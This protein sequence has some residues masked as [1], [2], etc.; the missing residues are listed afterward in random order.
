MNADDDV[1]Y[2]T[3]G[4]CIEAWNCRTYTDK[5][6]SSVS[7]EIILGNENVYSVPP[8]QAKNK[9]IRIYLSAAQA[10]TYSINA[11]SPNFIL[12]ANPIDIT[13]TVNDIVNTLSDL[14]NEIDQEL[15]S[16]G[17][18]TAITN[19][20]DTGNDTGYL[21]VEITTVP[22]WDYYFSN[23][24]SV[25]PARFVTV[26]EAIDKSLEGDLH[27]IGKYD[28]EGELIEW[29]ASQKN[30]PSD[31]Q[32][33]DVFS[34]AG[35]I[36]IK[37]AVPHGIETGHE[38]LIN[39][40]TG[41]S[42]ANGRW[43][44]SVISSDTVE[45]LGSTFLNAYTGSG[46]MTIHPRG[47]G[48]VWRAVKDNVT[49]TWTNTRLIGSKALNLVTKKQIKAVC[50]KQAGRKRYVWTD[51][52]NSVSVLYDKTVNYQQDCLLEIIDPANTY[53]YD[54]LASE[55]IFQIG[56]A[57]ID[58]RFT[59][60]T[61]GGNLPD[62]NCRYA[63]RL[64]T[65]TLTPTAWLPLGI[66]NP[67]PA[68][69]AREDGIWDDFIGNE[70]GTT[71]GKTNNFEVSG[72]MVGLY[73]W[74]EL[75]VVNYSGLGKNA[76]I[77]GRYRITDNTMRLEHNGFEQNTTTIDIGTI[78]I[79]PEIYDRALSIDE[80]DGRVVLSNL[81]KDPVINLFGWFKTW[82]WDLGY[83]ELENSFKYVLEE[84]A[85]GGYQLSR[86]VYSKS[87]YLLNER[88]R[89]GAIVRFKNGQTAGVFH[90]ADAIFNT[91]N[92]QQGCV[93]AL[94][95]YNLTASGTGY[96]PRA[97]HIRFHGFDLDAVIDGKRVRDYVDKIYIVRAENTN[98]T[99]LA[100]G[101]IVPAVDGAIF[102]S[103]DKEITYMDGA[104][105]LK[106]GEW[107]FPGTLAGTGIINYLYGDS[108]SP[109]NFNFA[110][111][112]DVCSFYSWDVACGKADIQFAA[113][114]KIINFGQPQ[115]TPRAYGDINFNDYV[116]ETNGYTNTT[117]EII[118][119][120]EGYYVPAGGTAQFTTYADAFSKLLRFTYDIPNGNYIECINPYS[121]VVRSDGTPFL[122][123]NGH[124]E[125]GCYLAQYYRPKTAEQQYG[126]IENSRYVWTGS[127]YNI[128]PETPAIPTALDFP[129]VYGGDVFTQKTILKNRYPISPPKG[130]G[131]GIMFFAQ[132][133][134]N[135][136]MRYN[137]LVPPAGYP[138]I[139][140]QGFFPQQW[141]N[142]AAGEPI[143]NND[144]YSIR[145][146]TVL[147]TAFNPEKE[148]ND[149]KVRF[150]WSEKEQPESFTDM[151]RLFLPLNFKDLE[152][153]DGEVVHHESGNDELYAWQP[154]KFTR[155]YFN[156]N[157]LLTSND[158]VEVVLGSG[159]V[160][161][162][163]PLR[164]SQY[165]CSDP[166][167]IVK[168]IAEQGGDT[169]YWICRRKSA[170]LRFGYDGTTNQGVIKKMSS[171]FNNKMRYIKDT[172]PADGKGVHGIWNEKFKEAV[173][174]MR[175]W[176][177][178]P[179][180]E[181]LSYNQGAVVSYGSILGV[182]VFYECVTPTSNPPPDA[183][184]KI[185]PFTN[186]DFYSVHTIVFSERKNGFDY[187]AS[188]FPKIYSSYNNTILSSES[189]VT[190]EHNRGNYGIWYDGA[191]EIRENGRWKGVVNYEPDEDKRWRALRIISDR[192]P[193]RVNMETQFGSTYLLESDFES[194]HG[195]H[196]AAIKNNVDIN[197][198][199]EED[200]DAIHGSYLIV[201]MEFEYGFYQ[202]LFSLIARTMITPR[203]R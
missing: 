115:G 196:D 181:N 52:Y 93:N 197:N 54:N 32:I 146:E 145:N 178:V 194:R 33:G 84:P 15:F 103:P 151:Q 199:T 59:G 95:D 51:R 130:F 46:I 29:Y 159:A 143:D 118:D 172:T 25:L 202:K 61:T 63:V 19:I 149:Y 2:I 78:G 65:S 180:W 192:T 38:V 102:Q 92:T 5:G 188:F 124:T 91:D 14:A 189:G 122:P 112:R 183:G 119:L 70:P 163:E 123:I 44:V 169:F 67:I 43:I 191:N 111:I 86:N 27:K 69:S 83:E 105:K 140:N 167:G 39:G 4:D 75:C 22:Y 7:R 116:F 35:V 45:L 127:V 3:D 121:H 114:D 73:D 48:E 94:S 126:S 190:Y 166:Y 34:A 26:R 53:S 71:C 21:D 81:S 11:Y 186:Q 164:L 60:Q 82:L 173:I 13:V 187:F 147:F 58:F 89:F 72:D 47:Y 113:G 144:G 158:G 110:T 156:S 20:T 162:R 101:F 170:F 6:S 1:R 50:K 80:I 179:A 96:K 176:K 74:I 9:I 198:S 137:E 182:P 41:T 79:M 10:G 24:P 16:S 64:L 133:R 66:D 28:M 77:V 23:N 117:P 175:G 201:E 100:S 138:P 42:E 165:G 57:N 152:Y 36:R 30:L 184:W 174:T 200:T 55:K 171:F 139:Y 56:G 185:I 62:G 109:P 8:L 157:A 108:S 161:S 90:I 153:K 85:I 150:I 154:D 37:T 87:G 128:T 106:L 148:V 104:A 98:P 195:K 177:D 88:Y 155:L 97:F 141:L 131:Q 120:E 135:F 18:Q 31:I 76:W 160:M 129:P 136:E 193:F 107:P 134:A 12:N 125:R 99:I 17:Y 203:T 49:G 132:N 142:K 40:V 168:G 68:V